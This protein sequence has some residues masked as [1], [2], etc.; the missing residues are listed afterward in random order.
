MKLAVFTAMFGEGLYLKEDRLRG[1]WELK[2]PTAST[3][4]DFYCY[5]DRPGITS[6]VWSVVTLPDAY[7]PRRAARWI[8][9]PAHTT[10]P[11]YDWTLWLDCRYTLNVD[12]V[13]I[14]EDFDRRGIEF[15]A[16]RHPDRDNIADE[17]TAILKLNKAPEDKLLGQ[18]EHYKSQG[19]GPGMKTLTTSGGFLL[20]KNSPRV[21]MFNA[22]WWYEV[23][24]WTLRDQMS[25][26]YAANEVGLPIHY[27]EGDYRKNPYSKWIKL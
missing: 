17:A 8:K 19:W 22:L 18:L 25:L 20:R 16:L 5:T 13:P 9:I 27:M 21:Q 6:P 24:K 15:A 10:L 14:A 3:S 12:P 4:A 2:E 26:D 7:D 1:G 23:R 11:D